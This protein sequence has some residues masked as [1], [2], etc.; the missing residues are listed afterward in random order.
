MDRIAAE[1]IGR[2]FTKDA[3]TELVERVRRVWAAM[4]PEGYA[5]TCEAIAS[6]DARAGHPRTSSPVLVIGSEGDPTSSAA[7]M[8]ELAAS[9]P[10]ARVE[11]MAR[12]AH[13]ACVEDATT[14][15]DLVTGFLTA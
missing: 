4:A 12:G 6:F 14:F 5:L 7:S 9:L 1:G 2:Y 3:P 11:I 15:N 10:D 8:R 13:L